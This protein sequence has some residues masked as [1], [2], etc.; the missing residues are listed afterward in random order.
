MDRISVFLAHAV[1]LET[2]AVRCFEDLAAAMESWGNPE[3]GA[4]FGR[5]AEY[6][7]LH[8]QDAMARAGFR[9]LPQLAADEWQWP[10]GKSP[11]QADW[12]GLDGLTGVEHALNLALQSERSSRD[13]YRHIA[14]TSPDAKVCVMAREFAAE[15]EAHV[16]EVTKRILALGGEVEPEDG[17]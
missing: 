4:F 14:N 11:E 3:V 9:G 5:M 8:Q 6:A 10:D 15:E 7:R 12:I 17:E 16:A 1:K 13:F 2:E